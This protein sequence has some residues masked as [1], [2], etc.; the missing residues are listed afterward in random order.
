MAPPSLRFWAI[1][2]LPNRC[3]PLRKLKPVCWC[4]LCR[5]VFTSSCA[6]APPWAI[7]PDWGDEEGASCVSTYFSILLETRHFWSGTAI[8]DSVISARRLGSAGQEGPERRQR[9]S[10]YTFWIKGFFNIAVQYL[11]FLSCF[12]RWAL[13]HGIHM[14]APECIC[15]LHSLFRAWVQRKFCSL[16]VLSLCS[17]A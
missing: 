15:G 8:S 17:A 5:L 7:A 6:S 13:G 4:S 10:S 9:K 11:S 3:S 2:C 14:G 1:L 16:Y 12:W